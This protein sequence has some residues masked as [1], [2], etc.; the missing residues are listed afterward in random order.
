VI[1]TGSV[2]PSKADIAQ[3]GR[4][5]VLVSFTITKNIDATGRNCTAQLDTKGLLPVDRASFELPR[6][7]QND[8]RTFQF[9]KPIDPALSAV[10]VRLKCDRAVSN[11][12]RHGD[13]P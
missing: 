8:R 5:Y 10:V 9:I 3:F 1:E 4:S 7:V 12:L 13:K 6:G 11:D 2:V